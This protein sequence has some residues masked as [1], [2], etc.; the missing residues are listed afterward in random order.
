MVQTSHQ[1]ASCWFSKALGAYQEALA[2]GELPEER[3]AETLAT[4]PSAA[5]GDGYVW[6]ENGKRVSETH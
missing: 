4:V 5:V 3:A 1:K 6:P 2:D